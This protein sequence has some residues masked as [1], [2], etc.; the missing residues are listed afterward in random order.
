MITKQDVKTLFD[1]ADIEEKE[2]QLRQKILRKEELEAEQKERMIEYLIEH[3]NPRA[4]IAVH[5]TDYF[6][7]NGII[8]PTGHYLFNFFRSGNAKRIIED[9]QLKHPRITVHFTL[10]YPVKGVV[11]GG[12]WVEW[13]GK[14]GILIPVTDFLDRIKCL[15][16]V[17]TWI[18][19]ALELTPSAE[20]LMNEDEYFHNQEVWD[21]LAGNA[22]IVPFPKNFNIHKAV[23]DRIRKKGFRLMEGGDF[24]W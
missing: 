21:E 17:D 18:V 14:Y 23:E 8:R 24:D 13:K 16:P 9:L 22:K 20:V 5:Q 19:G 1:L 11:A 12:E 3:L 6:P 4:L 2:E 10:N 7:E 15:N